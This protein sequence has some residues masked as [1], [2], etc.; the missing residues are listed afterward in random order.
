[1]KLLEHLFVAVVLLVSTNAFV[2][3]PPS[4]TVKT[5]A[6][7]LASRLYANKD[8]LN[9]MEAMI[10]MN[11]ADFCLKEDE[12]SLE[13]KDALIQTLKE[14]RALM[15]HN[16]DN[17]DALLKRLRHSRDST[18]ASQEHVEALIRSM[19]LV[20]DMEVYSMMLLERRSALS[21]AIVSHIVP[22]LMPSLQDVK[23]LSSPGVF[24]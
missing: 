20:L 14:Q 10:L 5:R 18:P 11:V 7:L 6:Q 19:E 3:R 24:E 21:L 15:A 2:V 9:D 1:M 8:P 22:L 12:C 4:E 13:D 16:M 17:L 23:P